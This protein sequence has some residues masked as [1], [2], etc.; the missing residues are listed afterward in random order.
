MFSWWYLI[1][2]IWLTI[3]SWINLWCLSMRGNLYLSYNYD[4]RGQFHR[5][6]WINHRVTDLWCLLV[7]VSF[8]LSHSYEPR[9]LS[10]SAGKFAF[11]IQQCIHAVISWR[12]NAKINSRCPPICI[13]KLTLQYETHYI[14]PL[15]RN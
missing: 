15:E 11:L 10:F 9:I 12:S 4:L 2:V 5:S 6:I 13:F 1:G 3:Q 8:Y 7:G 14:S